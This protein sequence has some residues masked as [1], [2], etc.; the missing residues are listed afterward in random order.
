[1]LKYKGVFFFSMVEANLIA[2]LINNFP[3]GSLSYINSSLIISFVNSLWL[4]P[5]LIN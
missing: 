3:L 4:F 5:K 2:Y 1:M